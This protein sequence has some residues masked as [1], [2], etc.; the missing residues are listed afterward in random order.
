MITVG[1]VVWPLLRGGIAVPRAVPARADLPITLGF[2][3]AG[4]WV[5]FEALRMA[6]SDQVFP[7][8]TGSLRSGWRC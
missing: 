8:V 7:L 4:A 2:L 3:A 6:V 1:G 5:V